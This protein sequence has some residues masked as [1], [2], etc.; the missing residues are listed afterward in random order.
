MTRRAL[1]LSLAAAAMLACQTTGPGLVAPQAP[2]VATPDPVALEMLRLAGTTDRDVVYDLGS[3]DGRLVIAAAGQFGARGVG[4]EIDPKLVQQS[5][6]NAVQAHVADRVRFLWQDIFASEIRDATV[7]TLYLGDELNLRLRP[8]LLAELRPGTRIVSH[9]FGMA[10]WTPDRTVIVPGPYTLHLW[11]VPANVGGRWRAVVDGRETLVNLSQ[12]FQKVDGEIAVETATSSPAGRAT[13][14]LA[15]RVRGDRLEL[16]ASGWAL[17]A[18]VDGE[19]AT[20]TLT[21]PGAPPATWDAERE[22]R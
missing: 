4:I 10:D 16:S 3:G 5:L 21:R 22:R 9:K 8:K 17:A 14:S 20:G 7:V 15:G 2:F 18:S 12:M 13:S 6:D 11:T 1:L 19:H